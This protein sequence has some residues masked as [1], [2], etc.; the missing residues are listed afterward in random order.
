MGKTTAAAGP[1]QE[2]PDAPPNTGELRRPWV[3]TVLVGLSAVLVAG[4]MLLVVYALA[5]FVGQATTCLHAAAPCPTTADLISVAPLMLI[6]AGVATGFAGIASRL[7]SAYRAGAC[8]A[9][10]GGSMQFVWDVANWNSYGPTMA[11]FLLW[12]TLGILPLTSPRVRQHVDRR[13]ETSGRP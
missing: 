11:G 13:P 1:R 2:A 8:L 5:G 7:R 3:L 9:A 4:P 12:G 6:F 10:L